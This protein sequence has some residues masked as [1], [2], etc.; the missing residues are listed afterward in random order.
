[1]FFD[2][3]IERFTK[4]PAGGESLNDVKNRAFDAIRDINAKYE[5]KNILIIGH[6]DPL[7]VLEGA[8][9]GMTNEEIL[10][11]DYIKV[12]DV[13][14]K[15]TMHNWPYN[16]NGELDLHRPYVDTLALKCPKCKRKMLRVPEVADVWFDSGAMP[17]AQ[18]HYPFACEDAKSLTLTAKS[19]EECI[20]FPA[21]Y[22]SEGIDQTRGWFNT[23][24]SVATALGLPNPYKN[25]ITLGLVL[26]KNGQKMSKSKGN[27]VSPWDIVNTYGADTLRWY[28]YTVN[29]PSE[30]KKFDE[31]DL[32]KM[33]RRFTMIIY[34]SFVFLETYGAKAY[35][36]KP[37]A[38]S[39]NVLDKWIVSRTHQTIEQVTEG[40][41]KYDVGTA[42]KA[43]ET[44]TDDL[45]RWYIR[46][47]R[48][49]LQRPEDMRDFAAASETLRESL[50]TLSR[51]LAPFMPF[52]AEALYQS[53]NDESGIRNEG[54]NKSDDAKFI[55]RNSVHLQDWPVADKKL[56]D[57]A[58]MEKMADVRRISSAA[59]AVR[60][61]KGV[62]VR[63]PLAA[64][65]VKSTILNIGDR[66]L[67]EI[68]KDEVNVKEVIWNFDM[69]EELAYDLTITPELKEEGTLREVVRMVQGLR[70]DANYVPG[71]AIALMIEGP[72]EVRNA[73]TTHRERLKKDVGAKEVEFGK[74]DKFDAESETKLDGQPIWVGVRKLS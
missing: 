24:L 60:A 41:E 47:S 73:L 31:A 9:R 4:S 67:L 68:L 28:F 37:M 12:E 20:D 21:D 13:P 51:L 50:V 42:G 54:K 10:N 11:L 17:F 48:S 1:T 7:W 26:D 56:I 15:V 57:Y 62:K 64:L 23:L 39:G 22:I 25:V 8:M 43:L 16:M 61:E 32:G 72:E 2:S 36:K 29:P 46:R 5:N 58:L 45:S 74:S 3:P 63:Q 65:T 53:L 66:E 44:F 35:S 71:D 55:I 40:L 59:L 69:A 18:F 52:F 30:F 19:L 38:N 6:G 14:R 70:H 49:R 34:N 33:L 27:T